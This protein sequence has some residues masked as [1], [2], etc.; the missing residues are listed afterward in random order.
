VSAGRV[1]IWDLITKEVLAHVPAHQ[2]VVASL[3]VMEAEGVCKLLTAGADGK[4]KLW[5]P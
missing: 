5:E 4:V 2:G 3:A 1:F